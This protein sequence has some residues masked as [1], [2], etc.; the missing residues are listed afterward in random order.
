MATKNP[1]DLLDENED[2][3]TIAASAPKATAAPA[4]KAAAETKPAVTKGELD[5]PSLCP[6]P[7]VLN[8]CHIMFPH[9]CGAGLG[10]TGLRLLGK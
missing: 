2:P 6:L 5:P 7:T 3:E 4:V 10:D 1:F 8:E 9:C